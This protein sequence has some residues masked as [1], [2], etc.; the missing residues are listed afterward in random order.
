MTEPLKRHSLPVSAASFPRRTL[1][2]VLA[3]ALGACS[4][5]P[6]SLRKAEDKP[7]APP[8]PATASASA[9]A[10][11][12]ADAPPLTRLYPGTGMLVKEARPGPQ[13]IPG[14]EE[15]SLNF[16][17]LDVREVA[18][19]I[20]ADYLKQSYTVHPSVTG[21]ITFRTVRPIA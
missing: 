16:E 13:Y 18:K 21:T 11:A 12:P 5:L 2:V 17:A 1:A 9:G 14:P 4:M 19:V 6:P 8:A 15:A 7:A 3:T 20:L 10:A